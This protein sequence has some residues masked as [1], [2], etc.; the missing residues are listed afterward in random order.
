MAIAGHGKPQNFRILRRG[1]FDM[2]FKNSQ[3]QHRTDLRNPIADIVGCTIQ[4]SFQFKFHG[5]Q[6]HFFAAGR[7]DRPESLN[8]AERVFE[9]CGHVQLDNGCAGPLIHRS[10]RDDRRFDVGILANRQSQETQESEQHQEQRHD[11]REHRPMNTGLGK[12]HG[13]PEWYWENTLLG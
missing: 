12:T 13:Y 9:R 5:D 1:F 3:R 2:G 4:V 7:G 10:N 11:D 6:R 8:T